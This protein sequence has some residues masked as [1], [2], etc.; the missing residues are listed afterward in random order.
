MANEFNVDRTGTI[1]TAL[2]FL[3]ENG[4]PSS[5]FTFLIMKHCASVMHTTQLRE[6][7]Y[8][9]VVYCKIYE[10]IF[11][12]VEYTEY[13]KGLMLYWRQCMNGYVTIKTF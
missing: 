8:Q 3:L 6:L 5:F 2:K 9:N 11:S 7:A 10:Q 4:N 1:E 12:K 13:G